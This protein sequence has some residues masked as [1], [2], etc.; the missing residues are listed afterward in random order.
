[1]VQTNSGQ[2]FVSSGRDLF[3]LAEDG[4]LPDRVD[5]FPEPI[6]A[7][8]ALPDGSLVLGF[9]D[10]ELRRWH[11]GGRSETISSGKVSCP[12]AIAVVDSHT[13]LVAQ[14]SDKC[15]PSAWC[16]DLL[17]R[18][19]TGTVWRIDIQKGTQ[20]K[21]A[22]RLAFPNGIALSKDGKS[23]LVSE[24]WRNRLISVPLVGGQP[25]TILADL[26]GYPS[27]LSEAKGGGF[28]LAIFAPRNRLVEFVL[29]ESKFRRTMLADVAPEF[30]IAPSLSPPT[31]FLEPLQCGSVRTMGVSKAWA[32]SRSYGL[33]VRLD[34]DLRPT[35]SFHSR[36]NGGRHGTTSV[37]DLGGSVLV[38]AKGAGAVITITEATS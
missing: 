32:P 21:I 15:R 12:T 31:T 24:C 35:R 16:R 11:G 30:W 19:A 20:L 10:G 27:R 38:A 1:M 34:D 17:E 14:G 3:L 36:A 18:N 33:V 2:V 23:A 4:S 37:L 13:I 5:S 29:K 22:D 6:S 9:D 8:S 26:P 28:W 25:S 7:L